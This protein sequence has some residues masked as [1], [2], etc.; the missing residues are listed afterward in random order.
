MLKHKFKLFHASNEFY[1]ANLKLKFIIMLINNFCVVCTTLYTNGFYVSSYFSFNAIVFFLGIS[2]QKKRISSSYFIAYILLF[3][4][5]L[6]L[7][8]LRNNLPGTATCRGLASSPFRLHA[9]K[10]RKIC[11]QKSI[12]DYNSGIWVC[13]SATL[14]FLYT[15]R[16]KYKR[17]ANLS[18]TTPSVC[19][20]L[21]V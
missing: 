4:R 14:K 11:N 7:S 5:M 2:Q 13:C 8:Y 3:V 17:F 12:M 9:D 10:N 21:L 19:I 16:N 15:F 20:S 6:W 18:L 1:A